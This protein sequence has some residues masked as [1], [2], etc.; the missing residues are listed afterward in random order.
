M[1]N[2]KGKILLAVL[3]IVSGWYVE[4]AYAAVDNST[5]S[6][7][8]E[9]YEFGVDATPQSTSDK[10]VEGG[11]H[12][13]SE[14]FH[15]DISKNVTF[16]VNGYLEFDV[17]GTKASDASFGTGAQIGS[18][19][20]TNINHFFL[21]FVGRIFDWQYIFINDLASDGSQVKNAV[22]W[23]WVQ[24]K[25]GPGVL[26]I[27][28]HGSLMTLDGPVNHRDQLFSE[29]SISQAVVPS[30]GQGFYYNV[31]T[32][33]GKNSAKKTNNILVG[34]SV[35]S[36]NDTLTN[37]T[38]GSGH[39]YNLGVRWAPIVLD[40]KWFQVGSGVEYLASEGGYGFRNAVRFYSGS[41]SP[42]LVLSNHQPMTGRGDPKGVAWTA[43]ALGAFESLY[44]QSEYSESRWWQADDTHSRL[45]AYTFEVAYWLTGESTPYQRQAAAYGVPVPAGPKGMWSVGASFQRARNLGVT[46]MGNQGGCMPVESAIDFIPADITRCDVKQYRGELSYWANPDMRFMMQVTKAKVNLGAAGIDS[47]LSVMFRGVWRFE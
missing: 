25:M 19:V 33:Y 18:R 30:R 29:R 5:D 2:P 38:G 35:Y 17:Y 3:V 47:P 42:A 44:L 46:E 41:E 13:S 40:R 27:G 7:N 24:R 12:A 22:I 14:N 9:N 36:L 28:Q 43:H 39:G 26:M 15:W 31:A 23:A 16:N 11:R 32:S 8:A 20:N 34:A 10:V 21:N 37:R 6:T 45:Q 4:A 1:H